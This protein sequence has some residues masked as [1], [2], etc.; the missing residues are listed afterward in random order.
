MNDLDEL[1]GVELQPFDAGMPVLA[2]LSPSPDTWGNNREIAEY[3]RQPPAPTMFGT[4]MPPGTTE[5]QVQATLSELGA[6]FVKDMGALKYPPNLIGFAAKFFKEHATNT[7]VPRQ[8]RC[9]HNFE[10][11]SELM[12]DGMANDFCNRLENIEPGTKR[13]KQQ[14]LTTAITWLAKLNKKLSGQQQ[15]P[16]HGSAPNS[17]DGLLGQLSEA[18]YNRV[19]EINKQAQAQTL[20]YLAAKY[21][22]YTSQEVMRIAQEYLNK[23]PERERAHFEQFTTVNGVSWV[24]ML[25]TKEAI[26][27]LY[28]AAIG[29]HSIAQDGAGLAR[30][31]SEF[32]AMLKIPSERAKYMRDPALQSRL[33]ELYSRRDG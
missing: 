8:V 14:F 5:A 29:A 15:S 20:N 17:A 22:Q 7:G 13:Q 4:P 6:L 25:N 28:D 24:S 33:R 30:E 27:F 12:N 3:Q 18:D 19:I 21:G 31:I 11:P 2:P 1:T 26:E 32:E 10:L 23:L 16:T 9:N